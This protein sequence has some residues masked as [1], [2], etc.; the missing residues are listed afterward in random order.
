MPAHLV[1][2]ALYVGILWGWATLT[3]M[4]DLRMVIIPFS[5]L[6]LI[7][8]TV[9]GVAVWRCAKNSERRLGGF[10]LGWLL[11]PI[12]F[13]MGF[14]LYLCCKSSVCKYLTH[15]TNALLL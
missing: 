3:P 14:T 1:L 9:A 6:V 15:N 5:L 11:R 7:L 10:W 8:M 4:A 12:F 13:G 2:Y